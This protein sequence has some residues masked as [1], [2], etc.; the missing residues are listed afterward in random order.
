MPSCNQSQSTR[1]FIT[2]AAFLMATTA[3]AIDMMLPAMGMMSDDLG[4]TQP[5][6]ISWVI[7]GI[8]TGLVFGQLLFGPLSDAIGRRTSIQIGIGIFLIGTLI[9]ALANSFEILIAGRILQG[10]GGSATRIVTQAM[11]RDR[12]AGREMARIMSFVM[13]IFIMV[14]V[15]AP[16]VGQAVL[17]FGS[18]HT[19]FLTLGGFS[20]IIFLWFTIRQPETLIER[21][22]I[23]REHLLSAF[24]T[25]IKNQKTMRFTVAAGISFGGLVSYLSS[26]QHIFQDIY[27]TGEWFPVLFGSTAASIAISSMVNARYVRQLGME[28]ICKIAFS[29]Q[30]LWSGIFLVISLSSNETGLIGWLIYIVPVLFLMGLTFA[31]L[32]SVA[33]EPMG[34]IAG[35]AST[36]IGSLMTAISLVVG[37]VF[38]EFMTGS[39]TP[40]VITFFATRL[41]ALALIRAQH[42]ASVQ[43]N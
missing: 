42:S 24:L 28:L 25:V 13:T 39:P 15:F 14:P 35:T 36:V 17:W 12:F 3:L 9:C 6:R 21:R 18:W 33:L 1:E 43:A 40:L 16:M 27:H 7:L 32:Q 29:A 11:V 37:V 4:L 31:N 5:H 38:S 22:S 41:I 26:A 23:T 19:L 20:T 8:F 10:F 30:I 2:L 34:A